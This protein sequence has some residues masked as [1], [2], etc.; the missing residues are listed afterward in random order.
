VRSEK[1]VQS[2]KLLT[3]PPKF[4]THDPYLGEIGWTADPEK[5]E[6]GVTSRLQPLLTLEID[7]DLA[8]WV[9]YAYPRHVADGLPS[10]FL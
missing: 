8:A 2:R 7:L 1:D 6:M 9:R 3:D 10:F 5:H 4:T